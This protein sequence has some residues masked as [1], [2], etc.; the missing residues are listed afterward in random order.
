M[1]S[2]T[3]VRAEKGTRED[4]W[5]QPES[6]GYV[7]SGASKGKNQGWIETLWDQGNKVEIKLIKLYSSRTGRSIVGWLRISSTGNNYK[8]WV[9]IQFI[10]QI[11][12][13][14]RIKGSATKRSVGTTGIRRHYRRQP[15]ENGHSGHQGCNDWEDQF[16]LKFWI[17]LETRNTV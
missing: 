6:T 1:I 5:A 17:V 8:S 3:R 15:R 4:E 12:T 9:M 16:S 2:G 14:F 10:L 13:C 7:W 11:G